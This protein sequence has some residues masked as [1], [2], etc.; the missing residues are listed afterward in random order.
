MRLSS[1]LFALLHL[2]QPLLTLWSDVLLYCFLPI[3]KT[4]L[5]IHGG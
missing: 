5:R 1:L 3:E 4:F 2:Q